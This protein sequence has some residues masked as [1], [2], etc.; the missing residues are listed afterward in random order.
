MLC[1]KPVLGFAIPYNKDRNIKNLMIENIG[2][3]KDMAVKKWFI[4]NFCISAVN[5]L[6][7]KY[8]YPERHFIEVAND[9][10]NIKNQLI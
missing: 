4:E 6:K 8:A 5:A 3:S 9:I 7:D 10:R 2:M 1:N